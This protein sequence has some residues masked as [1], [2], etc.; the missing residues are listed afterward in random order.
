QQDCLYFV[1]C[2]APTGIKD[3]LLVSAIR[4]VLHPEQHYEGILERIADPQ[5]QVISFTITEGG[6]NVDYDKHTFLW[7]TPAVQSDLRGQ[8]PA[9]SV[10]GMLAR[11]LRRRMEAGAPG[12]A[13]MSCDNVQHNGDILCFALLE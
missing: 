3:E 4:E 5:T 8:G 1:Q 10:F 2:Y 7:D 9:R 6:Y 11:G 12:L 13:L